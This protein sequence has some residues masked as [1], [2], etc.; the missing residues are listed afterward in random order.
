MQLNELLDLEHILPS[1]SPL[2]ALFI[3][4]RNKMD[5]GDFVLTIIN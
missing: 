5:H 1:V 2:G 4:M 3:F